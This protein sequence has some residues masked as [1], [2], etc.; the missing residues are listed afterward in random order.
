M[1]VKT[2]KNAPDELDSGQNVRL[3]EK[4]MTDSSNKELKLQLSVKEPKVALRQ[5]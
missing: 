4:K 5:H 3:R 2:V 1:G